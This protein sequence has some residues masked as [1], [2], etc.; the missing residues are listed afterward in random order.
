MFLGEAQGRACPRSALRSASSEPAARQGW[1][2]DRA[3]S[4][5]GERMEEGPDSALAQ[6]VWLEMFGS[7]EVYRPDLN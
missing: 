6:D 2:E 5:P 7:L 4:T 3:V 1:G